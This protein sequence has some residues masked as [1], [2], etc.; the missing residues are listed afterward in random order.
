MFRDW[1][2]FLAQ[3]FPINLKK[4]TLLKTRIL[5]PAVSAA[6]SLACWWGVCAWSWHQIL[7]AAVSTSLKSLILHLL[8]PTRCSFLSLLLP[9]LRSSESRLLPGILAAVAGHIM[10]QSG[11]RSH[12]S[13]QTMQKRAGQVRPCQ[14]VSEL[15]EEY[16]FGRRPGSLV[17]ECKTKLVLRTT[18]GSMFDLLT[19]DGRMHPIIC[20]AVPLRG[21]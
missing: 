13:V 5:I 16:A 10:V 14:D 18:T 15:K 12:W 20:R 19:Y 3:D 21:S 6:S 7:F 2:V 4:V 11:M 8:Q 1:Q 17:L 9:V